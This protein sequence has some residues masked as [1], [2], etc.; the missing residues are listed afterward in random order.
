MQ[1]SVVRPMIYRADKEEIYLW[2]SFSVEFNNTINIQGH[3][4]KSEN[5]CFQDRDIF[6]R[7]F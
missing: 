5:S 3:K 7:L 6:E 4:K 2:S 1:V